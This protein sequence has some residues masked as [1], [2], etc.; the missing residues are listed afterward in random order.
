MNID[1][2]SQ[3]IPDDHGVQLAAISGDRHTMPL[4]AVPSEEI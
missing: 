4:I 1:G 3:A 2:V